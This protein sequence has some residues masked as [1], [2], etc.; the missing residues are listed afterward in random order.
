M[1]TVGVGDSHPRR[2][3]AG[4]FCFRPR[5]AQFH[6]LNENGDLVVAEFVVRRHLE[7]AALLNGGDQTALLR[8]PGDGGRPALAAREQRRARR[9]LQVAFRF[10]FAV[11]FEA[12]GGED[13]PHALLEEVV[14]KDGAMANSQLTNYIIPTTLDTPEIDVAMLENPYRYGPF[15]AKGLG[16]LPIDGPAPAIVN[17]LRHAGYDIRELPA[18][19]ERLMKAPRLRADRRARRRD[20]AAVA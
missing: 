10:A 18:T 17:A 4:A 3:D 7:F 14:M 1:L 20:P 11:A 15:G 2:S 16:E 5:Q 19:P 8:F 6:P 9:E 13:G 12:L